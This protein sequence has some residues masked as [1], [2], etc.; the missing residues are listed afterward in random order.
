EEDRDGGRGPGR[1][2]ADAKAQAVTVVKRDKAQAVNVVK[3]GTAPVPVTDPVKVWVWQGLDHVRID[4]NT[5]FGYVSPEEH[6]FLLQQQAEVDRGRRMKEGDA[7]FTVTIVPE[8]K[9][10]QQLMDEDGVNP[11]ERVAGDAKAQA[12]GDV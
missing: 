7:K 3:R 8:G 6:A 10:A 12:G 4:P 9:T 1:G 5:G 2:H 11:D